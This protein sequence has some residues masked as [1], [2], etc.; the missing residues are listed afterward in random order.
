ME[1][2]TGTEPAGDIFDASDISVDNEDIT[3]SPAVEETNEQ[4]ASEE[5]TSGS[6]AES[7]NSQTADE[8]SEFLRKKGVQPN[9]PDALGKVTKMYRDAEKGFYAK[10]QEKA[11]LERQLEQS[12]VPQVDPNQEALSEVRSMK[13]S[14]E[15]ER[16]KAQRNL[17]PEAEQKM[18]E[19][20]AQPITQNGRTALNALGEPITRGT[21]VLNG[22]LSLDDV[23]HLA[24]ADNL[25]VD[26]LK[27]NLRKEVQTEMAARQ[28]AS[29]PK[30]NSTNSTVFGKPN[31]DDPFVSGFM[32]R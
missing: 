20:L 7:A 15:T 32:S 8:I 16:W 31:A 19:Y 17:S 5:E 23:Y 3:S 25:K 22:V 1:Q 30:S 18:V 13:T 28:S 26:N 2:Q 11:Q 9:D 12:K 14:M 29:R 27:E 10:A 24:G 6:T 4:S 21:L